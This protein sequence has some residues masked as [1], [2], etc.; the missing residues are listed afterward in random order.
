MVAFEAAVAGGI[1][2]IKALREGSRPTASSGWPA[3]S[4]APP[5]SSRPRCGQG[6]FADVPRE[7]QARLR[8]SRPDLRHRRR[9]CRPQGHPDGLHRLPGVPVQFDKAYVEGITKLE[10]ADIKY[11]EQLGY[12]IAAGIASAA[13]EGYRAARIRP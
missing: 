11:A 9:R 1:P 8:R 13:A 5:I 12:R 4:T 10:A 2:I 6:P 7:A 3:S